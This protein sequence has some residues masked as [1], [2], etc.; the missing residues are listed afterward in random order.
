MLEPLQW[1]VQL[2]KRFLTFQAL[3]TVAVLSAYLSCTKKESETYFRNYIDTTIAVYGPYHAI[4]LPIT[5]GVKIANPI[6]LMLG[7]HEVMYA[8]NQTGEVYSLQDTDQDSLEDMAVLY[9]NVKDFGLRSPGGLTYRGDTIF[10][11]TAQQIRAFLDVDKDGKAD[12]SWVFFDDIPNSE[13]PYEWTCGLNFGADNWLYCAISTDS[14]NVGASPDPKGYRGSILRISPNGKKAEQL[15]TGIRSVYDLAFSPSGDLF[16]TDNEGGGNAVEELNLLIKNSFYGHNPSK[17]KFDSITGPVFALKTEMA[18]SGIAFNKPDNNFGGT[19]GNLFIAFY[20]PGERWARGSVGR[21]NL[22]L[23]GDG[24]YTFTEFPVADVP[25]LSNLAFGKDGSLY[26]AQHGKADYWYNAVYENQGAF[27]KLIF[28]STLAS[29]PL[30]S[31]V[32]LTKGVT[33][34]NSIE[35]G[36]Q[37]FAEHACLACHAVDGGT[38]LLGPN[39]KGIGKQLSREE[40]LEEVLKPSERIKPSMMAV[41]VTKKD[42][43]VLVGRVVNAS[44]KEIALMLVGNH[45]VQI[46]RNEI[47][48]TEDEK[49]SL[50]YEGLLHNLSNAE[51]ESLLD[52]V[53]SLSN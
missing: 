21:I 17:Y 44:E 24:S 12:S 53:V 14:W 7:P 40:I 33:E 8:A 4:K 22:H 37:L 42:G 5:K 19:G 31:R 3:V 50:M 18:P 41:R 29:K 16:F 38:E 20:G 6:Q 9:C 23:R 45:V 15:A 1:F 43:Q 28:D 10:V 49:K 26:L 51:K 48:K 35:L 13:H 25:K 47:E 52:Y 30:K 27:Y 34:K 32:V 36:K 39:L 2:S 46:Q 11:G